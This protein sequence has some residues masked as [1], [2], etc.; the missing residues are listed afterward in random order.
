MRDRK[1]GRAISVHLSRAVS[2][3]SQALLPVPHA[4]TNESGKERMRRQGFGFEF[5][6]ELAADEPRMI[7][8]L[9]DLNVDAI[10]RAAGD[11]EAGIG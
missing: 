1:R 7:R 9:D 8:N 10:G 3:G 4:G 6:M 2:T 5:R 11:P